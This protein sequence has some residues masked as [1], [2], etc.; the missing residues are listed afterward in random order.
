MIL[1]ERS[2]SQSNRFQSRQAEWLQGHAIADMQHLRF[3]D[4]D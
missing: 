2:D 3:A 1:I 4:C